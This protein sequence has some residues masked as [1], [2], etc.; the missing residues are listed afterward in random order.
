MGAGE[1]CSCPLVDRNFGDG[2]A[3][4]WRRNDHPLLAAQRDIRYPDFRAG[5]AKPVGGD[6]SAHHSFPQPPARLDHQV[7]VGRSRGEHHACGFGV[8]HGLHDYRHARCGVRD[9]LPLAIADGVRFPQRRPTPLHRDHHVVE[10]AQGEL[11]AVLAGEA[12][13][14]GVLRRARRPDR[15]RAPRWAHGAERLFQLSQ[16]P[17]GK[18]DRFDGIP[19]RLCDRFEGLPSLHGGG[20]P[21]HLRGQLRRDQGVVHRC[22]QAEAVRDGRTQ[23]DQFAEIRRLRTRRGGIIRPQ[24]AQHHDITHRRPPCPPNPGNAC[25]NAVRHGRGRGRCR[26]GRQARWC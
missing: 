5:N 16:Q 19:Q 20:K 13:G 9:A 15:D 17:V 10:R 4:I 2:R 24:I 26:G 1:R 7:P 14:R 18:L 23:R 8:R 21:L 11:G 6:Q 12:G 22:H 25:G 3:A